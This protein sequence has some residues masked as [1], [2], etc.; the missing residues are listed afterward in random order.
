MSEMKSRLFILTVIL[1]SVS[2]GLYLAHAQQS[3]E[4][5][6]GAFLSTRPKTTNTSA[7]PRRRRPP[8]RSSNTAVSNAKNVNAPKNSAGDKNT[9]T[10][11]GNNAFAN[12]NSAHLPSQAIGLG[13]TLFMRDSE[14]RTV[15]V[16]PTHEFHNGD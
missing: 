5:V 9:N 8:Q 14:G 11:A 12:T 10:G 7:P 15:R 6:R 2:S 1:L 16:E 4:E 13:Y 3:D